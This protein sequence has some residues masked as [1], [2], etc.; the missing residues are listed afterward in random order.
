MELHFDLGSNKKITVCLLSLMPCAET[1]LYI[2]YLFWPIANLKDSGQAS[3][4]WLPA[5]CVFEIQMWTFQK[6]VSVM[7]NSFVAALI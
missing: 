2:W 5:Y 1:V 3:K 4:P 6:V 7:V